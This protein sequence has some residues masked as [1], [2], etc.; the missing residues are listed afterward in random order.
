MQRIGRE[1]NCARIGLTEEVLV[2]GPSRTDAAR[3]RGRT[4]RNT[5]V[6]FVGEANAG[7]LVGVEI[8]DATSTTL[9]GR[10]AALV[11]A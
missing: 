11:A 6:N 3:L 2:E 5:M 1:R 8:D 7:Q 9:S 4:R 10:Q